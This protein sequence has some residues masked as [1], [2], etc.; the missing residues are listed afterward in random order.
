MTAQI[1]KIRLQQIRDISDYWLHIFGKGNDGKQKARAHMRMFVRLRYG[2]IMSDPASR[3]ELNSAQADEYISELK[4]AH[5]RR[6]MRFRMRA[7]AAS[8]GDSI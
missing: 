6:L 2:I 1:K 3:N 7:T 8:G 5:E 4:Q